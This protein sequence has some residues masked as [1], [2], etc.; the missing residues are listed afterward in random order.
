[1]VLE[2]QVC[3]SYSRHNVSVPVTGAGHIWV[4]FC[5]VHFKLTLSLLSLGLILVHFTLGP[6]LSSPAP[7]PPL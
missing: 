3:F 7:L 2:G 1:M 4:L 6:K 5:K